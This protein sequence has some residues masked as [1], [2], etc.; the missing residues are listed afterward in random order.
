MEGSV[1]AFPGPQGHP[2]ATTAVQ[3][4]PLAGSQAAAWWPAGPAG[5][6][7]VEAQLGNVNNNATGILD[8]CFVTTGTDQNS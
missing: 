2:H 1:T 3:L 8:L 4:Q 6:A 5:T 7:S